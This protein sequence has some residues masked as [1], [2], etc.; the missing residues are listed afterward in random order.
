VKE[1]SVTGTYKAF[2]VYGRILA[3]L[4]VDGVT[5]AIAALLGMLGLFGGFKANVGMSILLVLFGVAM[6]AGI[7]C[8]VSRR[9]PEVLK[10]RLL[11]SLLISGFGV[12]VK[13]SCFFIGAVWVLVAPRQ[14][15]DED[16]RSVYVIGD[17]VY[18]AS[19]MKVGELDPYDSSRYLRTI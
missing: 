6:A 2:G 3:Y 4:F 19:G 11:V 12:V 10:G 14:L 15:V 17:D 7:Y 1:S 5:V 13:I 16:G 9:C 8:F 18:D